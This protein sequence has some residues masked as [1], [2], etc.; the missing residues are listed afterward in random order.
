MTASDDTSSAPHADAINA[1]SKDSTFSHSATAAALAKDTVY[2]T[3]YGVEESMDS[4]G[5]LVSALWG[6]LD[7]YVLTE[8][9]TLLKRNPNCK[10]TPDD[11]KVC[12]EY[13]L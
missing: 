7:D 8:L 5:E 11:V 10:L 3:A 1:P 6:C 9:S 2:L 12:H 13:S 4:F